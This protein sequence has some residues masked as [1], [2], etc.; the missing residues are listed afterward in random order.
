[1]A[2]HTY[3]MSKPGPIT[4]YLFENV[5]NENTYSDSDDS[6][7]DPDYVP[8]FQTLEVSCTDMVSYEGKQSLTVDINVIYLTNYR[9]L[10]LQNVWINQIV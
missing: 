10:H 9:I 7:K 5:E 8:P 2:D 1:M 6:Y 4:N 3:S